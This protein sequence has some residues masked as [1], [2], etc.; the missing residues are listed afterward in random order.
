[1]WLSPEHAL[2]RHPGA[3]WHT[4]SLAIAS[5]TPKGIDCKW[6]S[7]DDHWFRS[8]PGNLRHSYC[9]A[10]RREG[11]STDELEFKKPPLVLEEK[12]P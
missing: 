1:M 4:M 6:P 5:N 11:S 7:T 10:V 12:P 3:L 8:Y 2:L 9:L